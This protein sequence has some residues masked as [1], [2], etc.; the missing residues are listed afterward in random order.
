MILLLHMQGSWISLF[1]G[2]LEWPRWW[3]GR[4]KQKNWFWIKFVVNL[5]PRRRVSHTFRTSR[6]V[7]INS[8]WHAVPPKQ[9]STMPATSPSSSSSRIG[10]PHPPPSPPT[11]ATPPPNGPSMDERARDF[12][13][14]W[15]NEE[16]LEVFERVS[17]IRQRF[18]QSGVRAS[19]G[20]GERARWAERQA[21]MRFACGVG[22]ETGGREEL[23]GKGRIPRGDG[24]FPPALNST[25]L[26]LWTESVLSP[27][28]KRGE[29]TRHREFNRAGLMHLQS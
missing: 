12:L 5:R 16:D 28:G 13:W 14:D 26:Q 1:T 11:T 6:S 15:V 8:P 21:I 20:G 7:V 23:E 9:H 27:G 4:G 2:Y 25:R 24:I 18:D 19:E 22:A 29:R 17:H 3:L 10:T